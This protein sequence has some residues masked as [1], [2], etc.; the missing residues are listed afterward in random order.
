M[1]KVTSGDDF[2]VTCRFKKNNQL[3]DLSTWDIKAAIRV[4]SDSGA[5]LLTGTINNIS[6][7]T[8]TASF[9][10]Q[11]KPLKEG[12]YVLS[13]RL[14]SQTGPTNTVNQPILIVKD[15]NW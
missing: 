15:Q 8:F 9:S 12:Q 4:N 11:T 3:V 6:N 13:V 10:Q 14:H 5:V 1:I 2:I 7:G